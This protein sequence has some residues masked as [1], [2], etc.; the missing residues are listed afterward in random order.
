MM[1]ASVE[2]DPQ[3][4]A[5]TYLLSP[6]LPGRSYALTIASK[7]GLDTATVE[8]AQALLSP[9]QK[10]AESLLK[11]LQEERNLAVQKRREA[12]ETMAEAGRQRRELDQQ[13][14]SVE[15]TKAEML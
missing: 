1:N 6:G 7:L 5:P 11:E 2:L 12:E 10:G 8:E 9:A 14:A 15:E 4:L 13:L 3:A